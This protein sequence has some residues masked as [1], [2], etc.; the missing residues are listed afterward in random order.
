M[1]QVYSN[2]SHT[3]WSSVSSFS[4]EPFSRHPHL[5]WIVGDSLGPCKGCCHWKFYPKPQM[6]IW[7][8]L[9][10]S[11]FHGYLQQSYSLFC[12]LKWSEKACLQ[13]L[14]SIANVKSHSQEN[15]YY[16][17]SL[18]FVLSWWCPQASKTGTNWGHC[19]LMSSSDRTMVVKYK[20][21]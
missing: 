17:S 11:C 1:K 9:V 10:S 20:E 12:F 13:Q 18:P 15:L 7:I 6:P 5:V 16:I 4:L 14:P 8:A 21:I 2:S 19:R 3:S